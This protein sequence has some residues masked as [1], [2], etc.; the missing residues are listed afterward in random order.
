MIEGVEIMPK[1]TKEIQ[2]ELENKPIKVYEHYDCGVCSCSHELYYL[3]ESCEHSQ[4]Y[5]NKLWY[6]Q[7]EVD[8]L[9]NQNNEWNHR[10][11]NYRR[12]NRMKELSSLKV[13]LKQQL[14]LPLTTTNLNTEDTVE[15][16]EDVNKVID[17]VFHA[18][19]G[20]DSKPSN[21]NGKDNGDVGISI[22]Q[23]PQVS[24]AIARGD[25]LYKKKV[26]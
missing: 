25:N 14:D 21:Y 1:T 26:K 5:F 2:K 22:S 19:E 9:I 20:N 13:E 16:V 24:S 3:A 6:S 10:D 15:L 4:K 18:L 8:E 23:T 17:S 12:L 11:F 7:S